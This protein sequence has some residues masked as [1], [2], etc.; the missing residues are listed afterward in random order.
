MYIFYF[1][2]FSFYFKYNFKTFQEQRK[3]ILCSLVYS[4]PHISSKTIDTVAWQKIATKTEGYVAQDLDSLVDRA[5]HAAW[6][7]MGKL[8]IK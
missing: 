1:I 4:K 7:R 3:E 5:T 6:V 8:F 2:H